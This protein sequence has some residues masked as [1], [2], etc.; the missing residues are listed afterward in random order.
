MVMETDKVVFAENTMTV[1]KVLGKPIIRGKEKSYNVE[2]VLLLPGDT[3]AFDELPHYVQNPL[4]NDSI[5]GLKL[6]TQEEVDL[7][8]AERDRF[9]GLVNRTNVEM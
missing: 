7:K 2:S 6:L 9:L 1:H 5:E 3:I 8:L 4:L